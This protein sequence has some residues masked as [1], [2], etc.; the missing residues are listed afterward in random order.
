MRYAITGDTHGGHDIKRFMA[1]GLLNAGFTKDDVL[2]ITGDFGVPWKTTESWRNLAKIDQELL[3]FYDALPFTIAFTDGNHDNHEMLAKF[4]VSSWM[5]A[6]AH[7][8]SD[9]VIHLMRGEIYDLDG[10]KML[11]IGGAESFDRETRTPGIDWWPDE[12]ITQKDVYRAMRNLDEKVNGVVDL[13][14]SHEAPLHLRQNLIH[15]TGHRIAETSSMRALGAIADYCD[16]GAWFFGH[17]HADFTDNVHTGLYTS[18]VEVTKEELTQNL[19]MNPR[20]IL[21]P[22]TDAFPFTQIDLR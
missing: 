1:P 16:Y 10:L 9:S 4:P 12:T 2:I 18:V 11:T 20:R 6:P 19:N 7:F 5:G 17:H 8:I 13:I 21:A 3:T 22:I 14:V 15:A